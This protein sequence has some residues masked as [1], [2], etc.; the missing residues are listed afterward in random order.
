[1]E[2]KHKNKVLHL[3]NFF[4]LV[5][6]Y[7]LTALIGLQMQ[8]EQFGITPFWPASGIALA[9]FVIYGMKYW[10]AIFVALY[11]LAFQTGMPFEVTILLSLANILEAIIPLTIAIK[12][13][14]KGNL[15]SL[16]QLLLFLFIVWTGPLISAAIS[17]M[18]FFF[19]ST[20]INIPAHKLFFIWWLGNS[21]GILLVGSSGILLYDCIKHKKCI[22]LNN[23][24]LLIVMIIASVIS[25][26]AFQHIDDLDSALI[27][28]LIIPLVVLS[29]IFIGFAGALVPVFIA[30]FCMLVMSQ[31]FPPQAFSQ[32]PFGILYLDIAVLWTITLTGLLISIAYKHGIQDMKNRWLSTHDGLTK[33]HNRHFLEQQME[34][35]R[36]SLRQQDKSF[37]LLFLDLN[38]FKTINDTAGH[39]AGDAGLEHVS[40]LLEKS[41]RA[42]DTV[43]RWGGDEF[44]ILIPD[45]AEQSALNVADKIN[46]QLL[47]NPFI[48]KDQTFNLSFS[49]GI[50]ST[51]SNELPENV[52][53]RADRASYQAK[54]SGSGIML[55]ELA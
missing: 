37:F 49:I 11:L 25:I 33:L 28:N 48:F 45:C 32:Q 26:G 52:I 19:T 36:T 3:R 1:M 12:Y 51:L 7:Y 18:T 35:W 20:E 42:S 53:E 5:F 6:A 38:N 46:H 13:G 39:L 30:T 54:R 16:R 40:R 23:P 15:K 34:H 2:S 44:I 14:F 50:A 17:S 10:P 55:A 24:V 22:T 43:V 8:S 9:F 27:L 31:Q 21:F 29:S 4:G 47:I 41:I